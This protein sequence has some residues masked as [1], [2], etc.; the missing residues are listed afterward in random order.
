MDKYIGVKIIQ[1][2]PM[3]RGDYNKFKGWTIPQD[4][5]PNDEGYLV[6][7]KDGYISWSPKGIFE[8]SNRKTDGMTFGFAVEAMKNGFKVCRKG[9]NGKGM[10]IYLTTGS[11]VPVVNLKSETVKHLYGERLLECD[12]C[13]EIRSHVD[14]KAA[15]GTITIGWNPSQVDMLAED[16]QIVN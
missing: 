13:V 5:D 4:E 12:E 6:K 11:I 1:A 3:T 14:M 7:Y 10:F 8:D 2:E 15:D 9:W 16:W